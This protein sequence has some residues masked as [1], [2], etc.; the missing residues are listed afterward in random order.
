MLLGDVTNEES[1]D[2]GRG[3]IGATALIYM[4]IAVRLNASLNML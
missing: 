1:A 3:L 2:Y 4:G